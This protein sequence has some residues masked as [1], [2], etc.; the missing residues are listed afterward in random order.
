MGLEKHPNMKLVY[1]YYQ[2]RFASGPLAMW[3]LCAVASTYNKKS[4]LIMSSLIL[5]NK[6]SYKSQVMKS[7]AKL[8][9]ESN[10]FVPSQ[11]TD[12]ALVREVDSHRAERVD[13]V[14]YI[15]DAAVTFPSLESVRQ[16]RLIG[17]FTAGIMD[18]KYSYA[19]F[20][21]TKEL[22]ARFGL[23][24]NVAYSTYLAI[25]NEMLLNTFT[26]RVVPFNFIVSDEI[27]RVTA[28]EFV[29][30]YVYDKPPKLTF[31]Q[32][33]MKKFDM[34]PFDNKFQ[35]AQDM[36]Q[37]YCEMAIP[38]AA[39]WLKVILE[40]IA[41]VEKRDFVI[42]EDMDLLCEYFLPNM[43]LTIRVHPIEKAMLMLLDIN[44]AAKIEDCRMFFESDSCR[45]SFP[46]D[47][48]TFCNYTDRELQKMLSSA[49]AYKRIRDE[50]RLRREVVIDDSTTNSMLWFDE[51]AIEVK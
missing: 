32:T 21:A 24:A 40:A 50:L 47:A 1:D 45:L 46:Y 39:M 51:P 48:Q 15:D 23:F 3:H 9:P 2:R 42:A 33:N 6:G 35:Y 37:H 30:G 12:R 13:K 28:K 4:P 17:L 8:Y 26:E 16:E 19:D 10:W 36:V 44:A 43:S 11:P 31:R 38:R 7:F 34:T 49:S 5:A 14:W 25:K 22:S 29:N 27:L 20:Q 41:I 18:Q